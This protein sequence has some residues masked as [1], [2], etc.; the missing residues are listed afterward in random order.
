MPAK[1]LLTPRSVTRQGHPSLARLQEAGFELVFSQPGSL[2]KEDELI[3]LLPGCAGWIAGVEPVSARV[4]ESAPD[5]RVIS[6]NGTG[7]DSIDLAAAQRLGIKVLR[8]RGANARGVAELTTALMLALARSIPA[9]DRSLKAGRWERQHGFELEGKTLGLIGCG[10]IGRLVTGFA[11]ALGMRVLAYDPSP[12]WSDAPAG[13]GYADRADVFHESDILSLHCPPPPDGPL[14]DAVTLA[15][16]K[17]GVCIINTARAGLLD[18]EATLAALASGRVAGVALDVFE[19]EPP[20][21]RRLLEHPR[22]IATPHIGGF[23]PQS[24]DRAMTQAVD[25]L[26]EALEPA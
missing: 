1:I 13:F 2:P 5:L 8:A 22:V 21:D 7:A 23:T 19:P 20:G 16:L 12:D 17:Q 25:N 10:T 14:L 6:R 9:T 4:L 15:S 3:S 11:L 26:L 18:T 24:I